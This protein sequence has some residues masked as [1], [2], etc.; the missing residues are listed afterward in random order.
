[1]ELDSHADTCVLGINFTILEYSG[2]VC[3]VYPYSSEYEAVK[4]VPIVRGATAVQDQQTGELIIMIINEG[5]WYGDKMDHS[6]INPNQLRYYGIKVNDNPFSQQSMYIHHIETDIMIP[7]QAQGTIIYVN[8]RVPTDHE[9]QTCRHIECTSPSQWNPHTVKLASI[10]SSIEQT[11]YYNV[12]LDQ[13]YA[14]ASQLNIIDTD[15]FYLSYISSVYCSNAFAK[16]TKA[17]IVISAVDVPPVKNFISKKRHTDITAADLSNRWHI[18]VKQAQDTLDTT[19]QRFSRSALQPLSRRYRNDRMFYRR[20]LNHHFAA[21]LYMARTKSLHGNTSA[22]IFAHKCGFAQAYPQVDKTKSADSLRQFTTDFGIPRKLTVDGALEQIGIHTEFI[23]R[24]RTYDINLHISSPHR[25]QE[26]P[27]EGVIREVRKKWFRLMS[28]TNMPKRLWDYGV[29]WVCEIMQ[30]T[31]NTSYHSNGRTPLEMITGDTPDISEYLDFGIYD[32]VLYKDNAGMGETKLGRMLGISHR[33]GPMMSYFILPISCKIISCTTVQRLTLLDQQTELYINRCNH[34]DETVKERL[35]DNNNI[36]VLGETDQP[37]DWDKYDFSGDEDFLSEYGKDLVLNDSTIPEADDQPQP[38]EPTPD[39]FDPYVNMEI[40]LPRG[41]DNRMEFAKVTKRVKDND[42]NP[43]G[44]ANDN[45]IMDSRLYIVEWNDGRTEEVMANVIAENLFAQVD[46]EGNSFVLLDDIIDHRKSDKALSGDDGFITTANGMKRRRHTTQGWELCV[47]WKN[48]STNWIPLKDLKNAYP[49]QVAEYAVANKIHEEPAFAWWVNF[50]LKKR[51]R[52]ISKVKSKYWQRTHK[53]GVEIPK[54]VAHALALDK[55]NG[56]A[57]WWD[58][59]LKEMANVR[60]AFDVFDG[61]KKDLPPGFQQIACHMIFDVKLGE[62]FRRKARYVAGG[63]VTDPPASITYSSVVTRESVRI[64]LLVA[65]LNDLEV[66]SADIQNAYLHAKCREKIWC[67]AGPEFGSDEGRIMIIVRALYG[68][69]SSGAAFRSLLANRLHEI[70]Y[71]PTKGDPDVWIRPAVKSDGFE[72]YEMV[73][74]YVDDIFAISDK[75]KVTL[76]QI[77]EDFKFKDGK[78]EPPDVYLG[79]TLENKEF[80]G[81]KCWTMASH[82]YVNAAIENVEKKLADN[83][84]R[85]PKRADTPM[86]SNYRPEEDVTA[87]LQGTEHT[88]FQELIGILRWAIEL[89]RIDIM[90]E[91]SM[92]STHLAMSRKG[93]LEQALHIFA[94]LKLN[95]KKTLAFDP[96]HP[97]Y[98]TTN[99]PPTADWHDFYRDAAEIIPD[100]APPP[101][102]RMVSM[103]CFVDAD[104]ASNRVTRRSQTGIIVFLNRAPIAWHSKRQNTVES[105]TFG[106]EYIAMK[107]AVELLQALRYKL[108]WFGI[109]IDG[110]VNVFGDNESVINSTQKPEATLTK[111]HNGIAYHKCREAVASGIIRVAY[112]NTLLN[113][114]DVLTKPL[115]KSRRDALIDCFMY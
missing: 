18:G 115:P 107:T 60:I 31:T 79:S 55:K 32:W 13:A 56:N 81:V 86:S 36:I 40:S 101:R 37:F 91:V 19:T 24:V 96:R 49:I 85:L 69:K 52:F 58:A 59:I 82:K 38:I 110:P 72:Y 25:P 76:E 63:H 3:D 90:M 22:Y 44:V 6:L 53:Y 73:L 111:K 89:G 94:Y 16:E 67:I 105:S 62:N 9:L 84:M 42:G 97:L 43:I 47:Q 23:R 77:Q 10:N 71:I 66:L 41:E 34:F 64:A 11:S 61:E 109:P 113:L 78:M 39:S 26:N 103:H 102:G 99:F 7:L 92:L 95:P 45:P 87:E 35:R 17:Q 83:D 21:D 65:A 75:P 14:L 20:Y 48:N 51:Q 2:R 70:G 46:D 8:S 54:S 93:H 4:D 112:I 30:R 104:H 57:L 100:D 1:M 88:Y 114:A 27:A 5:L 15:T 28:A 106:S 29:Q 80:N 12:N 50:T 108:R 74:V 33:I 98:D 68:L